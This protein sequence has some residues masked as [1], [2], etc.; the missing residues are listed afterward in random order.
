MDQPLPSPSHAQHDRAL[1]AVVLAVRL[2]GVSLAQLTLRTG[3]PHDR[4]TALLSGRALACPVDP[5]AL[6]DLA[7]LSA[8]LGGGPLLEHI[9]AVVADRQDTVA[10]ATLTGTTAHP[11]GR[12]LTRAVLHRAIGIGTWLSRN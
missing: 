6:D 3:I 5:R 9:A 4:L 8:I 12:V 2:G 11:A 7:L 1:D 10:T